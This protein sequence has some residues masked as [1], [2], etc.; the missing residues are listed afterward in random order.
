MSN[1]KKTLNISEKNNIS[2]NLLPH[3]EH[4]A[5]GQNDCYEKPEKKR[6]KN[7]GNIKSMFIY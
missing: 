7:N 4:E 6:K 5:R 1:Q 3:C 2:G